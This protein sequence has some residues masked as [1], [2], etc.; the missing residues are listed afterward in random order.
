MENWNEVLATD[1][2]ARARTTQDWLMT[3]AGGNVTGEYRRGMEFCPKRCYRHP[4]IEANQW[5]G[6]E[7]RWARTN[8]MQPAGD[9][10]AGAIRLVPSNQLR[11]NGRLIPPRFAVPFPNPLFRS[12]FPAMASSPVTRW[13]SWSGSQLAPEPSPILLRPK[14]PSVS[15]VA[16]SFLR[17]RHLALH[18]A[19]RKTTSARCISRRA[20]P[21]FF[22]SQ[23]S[24][25]EI[26]GWHSASTGQ[27]LKLIGNKRKPA[28]ER[29]RLQ[30]E[31][32]RVKGDA[33]TIILRLSGSSSWRFRDSGR[34]AHEDGAGR[35]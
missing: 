29:R 18:S 30:A 23:P 4:T 24:K 1:P 33:G 7:Q 13:P 35:Q 9:E 10:G 32:Q 12:H 22:G 11:S 16:A 20:A 6:A 26:C 3:T 27:Y 19:A 2:A 25:M 5:C 8:S 15:F 21:P 31:D 28:R 17:P 34:H 14:R